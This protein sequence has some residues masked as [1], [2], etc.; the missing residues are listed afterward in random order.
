M[1]GVCG[2]V[3]DVSNYNLDNSSRSTNSQSHLVTF[4]YANTALSGADTGNETPIS[5]NHNL[6]NAINCQFERFYH[7]FYQT[8]H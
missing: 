7:R 4:G 3:S 1:I 2:F 6:S 5:S 8:M